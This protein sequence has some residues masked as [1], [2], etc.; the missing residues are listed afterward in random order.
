MFRYVDA[1]CLLPLTMYPKTHQL[2]QTYIVLRYIVLH[3]YGDMQSTMDRRTHAHT[4]KLADDQG[5]LKLIY[6][7]LL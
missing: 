7:N 1:L 5:S 6:A 2:S 4:F 3:A